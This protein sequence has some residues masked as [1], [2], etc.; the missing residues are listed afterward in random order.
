MLRMTVN[1]AQTGIKPVKTFGNY[2]LNR[3]QNIIKTITIDFWD[4]IFIYPN[5]KTVLQKRVN[6]FYKIFSKYNNK[7]SKLDTQEAVIS[8][9]T[10][11]E[12]IWYEEKRTPSAKEMI[13]YTIDK[14]GLKGKLSE[15][16]IISLTIFNEQYI[17]KNEKITL[18][19][20]AD[21]VI[22]KLYEKG[23]S[24]IIISDTGF[25]PGTELKKILLKH[26]LLKYFTYLIFSDEVGFS[27]PD[28]K[29]FQLA[30]EKS[31][32]NTCHFNNMIHIGDREDK[33]VLGAK[34]AGMQSILF[35]GTRD[36]DY[37]K[38]TADYKVKSWLKILEIF[39]LEI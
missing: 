7:I 10:F 37:E 5:I 11:F 33:D 38:T 17:L 16:N 24:L 12:K 2:T 1:S 28:T 13:L 34:S 20:D 6:F 14:V 36:E 39:T 22:K 19:K 30:Q 8:I 3:N 25:E 4:T 26:D 35:A 27:K 32:D 21:I 9:Y 18:I 29:A 31:F 15:K 23:Y